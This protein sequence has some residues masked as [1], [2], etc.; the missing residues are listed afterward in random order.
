MPAG[1][2]QPGKR[3]ER[4]TKE[5]AGGLCTV[6]VPYTVPYTVCPTLPRRPHSRY[7]QQ[8]ASTVNRA[9]HC[10]A[11]GH[12]SSRKG[13]VQS[14]GGQFR[15]HTCTVH[16]VGCCCCRWVR[17]RGTGCCWRTG[18]HRRCTSGARRWGQR[19][20]ERRL[21]TCTCH[22]CTARPR[23]TLCCNR[24]LGVK[25][26]GGQGAATVE[27]VPPCPVLL[28]HVF[29][30]PT[31]WLQRQEGARKPSGGHSQFNGSS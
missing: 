14:V 28:L 7:R 3:R 11:V 24:R 29:M 22:R 12:G 27:L 10:Q 16:T 15:L 23:H 19:D 21:C 18:R 30:P 20:T 5:Q 25:R 17:R 8:Q 6:G 9:T 31:G 4:H 1:A 26:T 2:E 13:S